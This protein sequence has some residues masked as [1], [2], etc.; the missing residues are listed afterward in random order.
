MSQS[1]KNF[2]YNFSTKSEIN[3]FSRATTGIYCLLKAINEKKKYL[4]FPSTICPSPIYASIFS[5]IKI[6]FCDVNFDDGNINIDSLKRIINKNKK[7]IFGIFVPNMYGNP[8]E[9]DKIKKLTNK[10]SIYLIEDCAQ[11][12]GSKYNNKYTGTNGDISIFSFGYSKNLDVGDGGMILC[13]DVNLKNEIYEIYEKIQFSG[14]DIN[15]LNLIYKKKYFEY[16]SNEKKHGFLNYINLK[17]FKPLFLK[18]KKNNWVEKLDKKLKNFENL[19]KLNLQKYNLYKNFLNEK[20]KCMK[21]SKQTYPW[22]FNFFYNSLDR[23]IKLKNFWK[24]GGHANK[25]YPS[26][27]KFLFGEKKIFLNSEKIENKIINLPLNEEISIS[28]VK[29]NIKL[30][31]KIFN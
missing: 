5:D 3:F 15:K 30:I 29:K 8:C 14:S 12:L 2:F 23:D 19:K 16:L 1:V 18:K 27:P 10:Y 26:I 20:Y 7:K 24:Q 11:S 22:R 21:V 9:I 13:N 31:L 4:I 28:Q 25:L 17:K 6:I